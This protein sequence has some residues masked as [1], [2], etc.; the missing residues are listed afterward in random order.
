MENQ[1]SSSLESGSGAGSVPFVRKGSVEH[2]IAR[3]WLERWAPQTRFPGWSL[4]STDLWREAHR[5]TMMW[6]LSKGIEMR[7]IKR[8]NWDDPHLPMG[9]LE[10]IVRCYRMK[11]NDD[12]RGD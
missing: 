1:E 2:K 11:A 3:R 6:L 12:R 9:E 8:N 5:S 7:T 10:E 4:Y